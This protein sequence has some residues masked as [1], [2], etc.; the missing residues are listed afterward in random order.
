[1]EID[2]EK[3]FPY[4]ATLP[5]DGKTKHNYN[6]FKITFGVKNTS[7]QYYQL[8]EDNIVLYYVNLNLA[9]NVD[10]TKNVKYFEM[11]YTPLQSEK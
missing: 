11:D 8:P 10:V 5:Y 3:N 6:I 7:K 9:A 1:M 4:S 2:D